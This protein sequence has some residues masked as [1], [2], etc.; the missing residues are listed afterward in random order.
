MERV[1]GPGR[2]NKTPNMFVLFWRSREDDGKCLEKINLYIH[3]SLYIY[4]YISLSVSLSIYP[5]IPRRRLVARILASIG[6]NDGTVMSS[7]RRSKR[8]LSI[9]AGAGGSAPI[10]SA[11]RRARRSLEDMAPLSPSNDPPLLRVKRLEE[12]EE[13]M[14]GELRPPTG[15]QRTK[16][17]DTIATAEEQNYGSRRRRRRAAANYDPQILIEHILEYMRE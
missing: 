11:H 9:T 3:P 10:S 12:E 6:P 17:I 7:A 1:K 8:D 2:K 16:R 4:V 5:S 15:L 13:E 14:G